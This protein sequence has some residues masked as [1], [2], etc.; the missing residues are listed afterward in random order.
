MGSASGQTGRQEAPSSRAAE[1]TLAFRK[2]RIEFLVVGN[3]GAAL[4]GAPVATIDIDVFVRKTPANV[5]KLV[6]CLRDLGFSRVSP[7]TLE[8]SDIAEFEASGFK[9]DVVFAPMGIRSF[10]SARSRKNDVEVDGVAV[11]VACLEDII[12]SK[13]AANRAKDRQALPLLR[14]TLAM[15][16]A[17]EQG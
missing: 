16:R 11:P 7:R 1:V 6:E 10:A 15:R 5:S 13:E 2:H 3:A 12:A 9:L 8:Q 4:L 17:Q 14:A